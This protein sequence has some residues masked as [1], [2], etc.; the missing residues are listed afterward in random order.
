MLGNDFADLFRL[1]L[2]VGLGWHRH[3]LDGL[4]SETYAARGKSSD[5]T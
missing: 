1:E 3:S 5:M 2:A 4:A